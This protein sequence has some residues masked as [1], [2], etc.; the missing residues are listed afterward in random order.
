M[1]GNSS[2]LS[3]I[4]STHSP[5]FVTVNNGTKTPVQ[6]KNIVTNFDLTFSNVLY[7]PQ[8]PFNL[9]SV[10]K[11]IIALNCFVAFYP[12]HCEFQ[13]L[14]MKRMIGGGFVKNGLYYFQPSRTSVPFALHSTNSPYRG[15]CSLAHAS[16]SVILVLR[17]NVGATALPYTNTLSML[18]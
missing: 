2:L 5:S 7:L 14:K 16:F 11:L 8:F 6:G 9:L 4:S 17:K 3:H 10:H 18:M 12:S 15:H 13:D 1:T